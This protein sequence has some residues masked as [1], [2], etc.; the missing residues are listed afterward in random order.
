MVEVYNEA[1]YDL[2]VPPDEGHEKLT[3]QKQGKNVTVPVSSPPRPFYNKVSSSKPLRAP[4]QE[5][6]M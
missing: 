5:V 2:L 3:I 4:H 1:V 6:R